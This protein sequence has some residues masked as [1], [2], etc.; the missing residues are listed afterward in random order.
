MATPIGIHWADIW[1]D[2]WQDVWVTDGVTPPVEEVR[3]PGGFL[4]QYHQRPIIYVD[5]R[6]NPMDLDAIEAREVN[7]AVNAAKVELKALKGEDKAD[8]KEALR[9]LQ[10]AVAGQERDQMLSAAQVLAEYVSAMG[11]LVEALQ[12]IEQAR[13]DDEDEAIAVLLLS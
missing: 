5:K 3:Q 6:G 2:I 10:R 11:A 9:D 7:K 1:Q 12:Q 4:P 8:A 13:Q